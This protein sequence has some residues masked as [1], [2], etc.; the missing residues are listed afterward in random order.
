MR[1]PLFLL[2]LVCGVAWPL[3]THAQNWQRADIYFVDWDI[4]TPIALSP[5]QIHRGSADAKLTLRDGL[6]EFIASLQLERL[7]PVKLSSGGNTRLVVDLFLADGGNPTTY[8]AD[9]FHLF[10]ADGSL[11][12]SIGGSFRES[13]RALVRHYPKLSLAPG[14]TPPASN[15]GPADGIPRP[16]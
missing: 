16:R 11:R 1:L 14:R 8:H 10:N 4:E 3:S 12:R 2:L 6:V 5:Y 13:V 7:R 15:I 9:C